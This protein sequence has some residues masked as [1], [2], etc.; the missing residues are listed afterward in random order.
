MKIVFDTEKNQIKVGSKVFGLDMPNTKETEVINSLK[1]FIHDNTNLDEY[2]SDSMWMSYRYCIGSH[3]IA[4]HMRASDIVK[5]CYGRLSREQSIFNAFDMNREMHSYRLDNATPNWDHMA[6][7]S[8]IGAPR[9]QSGD[10][11]WRAK[12]NAPFRFT[13]NTDGTI[14]N[15]DLTQESS[16]EIFRRH[17]KR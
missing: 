3:T 13:N 2:D 16:N 14:G 10:D 6:E 11:R 7:D 8:V 9:W 5:H 15:Y 12:Q 1:E 4:A 17:Y